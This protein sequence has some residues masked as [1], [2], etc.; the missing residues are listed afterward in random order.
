[1]AVQTATRSKREPDP[2][3][4]RDEDAVTQEPGPSASFMFNSHLS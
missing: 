1:M 2:L 4:G 3:R